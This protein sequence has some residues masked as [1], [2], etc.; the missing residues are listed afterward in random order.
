[1]TAFLLF[2]PNSSINAKP[3]YA[4]GFPAQEPWRMTT[5]ELYGIS[6]GMSDR[7]TSTDWKTPYRVFVTRPGLLFPGNSGGPLINS[8]GQVVGINQGAYVR[9]GS[10]VSISL[11]TIKGFLDE[12]L[13]NIRKDELQYRGRYRRNL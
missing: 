8:Y 1:M 5:G 6:D 11:E 2:S 13:P 12:I 9:D 10:G 4:I 3:V 7:S